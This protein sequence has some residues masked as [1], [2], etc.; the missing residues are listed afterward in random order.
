MD[1]GNWSSEKEGHFQPEAGRWLLE[2]MAHELSYTLGIFN[3]RPGA[4]LPRHRQS[5]QGVDH[6]F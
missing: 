5:P 6:I 1:G 3:Q 2:D 4:H